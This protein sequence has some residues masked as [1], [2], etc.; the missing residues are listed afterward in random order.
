MSK[1]TYRLVHITV[2]VHTGKE[3][4][5]RLFALP[6]P[7]DTVTDEEIRGGR[8]SVYCRGIGEAKALPA[9]C[10]FTTTDALAGG[11]P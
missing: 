8:V 1:T 11:Q 7:A 3:P 5:E 6:I 4:R 2:T 10:S 9:D